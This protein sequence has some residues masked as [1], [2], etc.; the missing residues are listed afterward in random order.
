METPPCP[1]TAP[2]TCADSQ[3]AQ[4][5]PALTFIGLGGAGVNIA[6]FLAREA[7][8]GV[9]FAAVNTDAQSLAPLQQIETHLL[10][11]EITRGLGAGGDPDLGRQAAEKDAAALARLCAGADLVFVAAGL[12]GGTGTG[13]APVLARIARE[14]G[15]LVLAFAI[16]PFDC[17]GKRRQNQALAGLQSLKSAADGVICLPNQRLNR[18]ADEHTHLADTFRI[19]NEFLA[20]T[21]RGIWRMLHRPGLIHTD[22]SHLRA[23]LQGRHTESAFATAQA[24]GPNRARE[25]TELLLASPLLEDPALLAHADTALVTIAA[26]N[27]TRGEIDRVLEPVNRQCQNAHIML[28]AVLDESL[29]DRIEINLIASRREPA[30]A[31]PSRLNAPP[32]SP[33]PPSQEHLHLDLAGFSDAPESRRSHP[34]CLPPPPSLA[35]ET[36]RQ[37]YHQKHSAGSRLRKV[38]PPRF[39][40]QQLPLEIISKGRF[41]KSD[42]TIRHGE[43]L[44]IPTFKRRGIPLN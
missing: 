11:A 32:S 14:S 29:G 40:Q 37:L 21:I 10:A 23:A 28:G 13:A 12:G 16:L 19:S 7:L 18:I 22:F 5:T 4:R 6:Q 15:A 24:A 31:D 44:D 42:P 3:L 41:E 35:P 39:R 1:D 33:L 17:E 43:D 36:T 9:R 20:Q 34:E 25:A 8:P 38:I 27:L 2:P 26:H 30:S